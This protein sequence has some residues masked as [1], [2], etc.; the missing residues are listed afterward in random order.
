MMNCPRCKKPK[1]KDDFYYKKGTDYKTDPDCKD[2]VHEKREQ[3]IKDQ[4]PD[5]EFFNMKEFVKMMSI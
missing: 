5:G 2:C 1:T 4:E 3:K